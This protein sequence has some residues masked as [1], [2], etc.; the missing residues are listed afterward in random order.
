MAR[1]SISSRDSAE[2][3][4]RKSL[5]RA[6]DF[7]SKQQLRVH[8]AAYI[9]HWNAESTPFSWTKALRGHHPMSHADTCAHFISGD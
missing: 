1:G 2:F 4:P 5:L 3:S 7:L 9:E 8:I 6:T